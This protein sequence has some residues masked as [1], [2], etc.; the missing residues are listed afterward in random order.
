MSNKNAPVED[1]DFFQI[2]AIY[3]RH[4]RIN[5]FSLICALMVAY[6]ISH[7]SKTYYEARVAI[8]PLLEN[9][10]KD[11]KYWENEAEVSLNTALNAG[12]VLGEKTT[13]SVPFMDKVNADTLHSKYISL[14][15]SKTLFKD[16]LRAHQ[17]TKNQSGDIGGLTAARQ[18]EILAWF[19]LVEDGDSAPFFKISTPDVETARA[20]ITA[21]LDSA[22]EQ[23]VSQL[24]AG[25][26]VKLARIA[27]V[28]DSMADNFAVQLEMEKVYEDRDK[29]QWIRQLR[30]NAEIARNLGISDL[31]PEVS[32]NVVSGFKG[33]FDIPFSQ[34]WLMP[35]TPLYLQGYHVLEEQIRA[36][37]KNESDIPAFR[38]SDIDRLQIVLAMLNSDR[39]YAPLQR[40]LDELAAMKIGS[41]KAISVN[42]SDIYFEKKRPPNYYPL[43]IGVGVL[44]S[45]LLVLI[46]RQVLNR[47][48]D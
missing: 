43:I 45:I 20:V 28:I 9:E 24:F 37:D 4:W 11:F 41:F 30:E 12:K 6:G 32:F 15:R 14:L 40:K 39:A 48:A 3:L 29:Q 2:L 18:N 38:R 36:F 17:T 8:T 10:L 23:I 16:V 1:I 31:D 7:F 42:T 22:N 21:T 25:Y 13:V 27:V 47:K 34:Q 33:S 46:Y 44:F 35:G 5:L 26:D 19:E